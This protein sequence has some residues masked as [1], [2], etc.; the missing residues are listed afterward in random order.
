MHVSLLQMAIALLLIHVVLFSVMCVRGSLVLR[1]PYYVQQSQQPVSVI[2]IQG[3]PRSSFGGI[4]PLFPGMFFLVT[5][6]IRQ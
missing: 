1:V 6:F 5:I 3:G 4:L 2:P